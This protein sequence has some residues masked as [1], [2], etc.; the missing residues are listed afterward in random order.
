M[1]L[2]RE[3]SHTEIH[4]DLF[5]QHAARYQRHHLSFAIAHGCEALPQL[6]VLECNEPLPAI[7]LER[8]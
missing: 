7:R 6:G 1:D 4:G 3:L 5:I 8:G 2:H